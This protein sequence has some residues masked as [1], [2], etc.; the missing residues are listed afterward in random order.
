[1]LLGDTGVGKTLSTLHFLRE[2]LQCGEWCGYV[3]CDEVPAMT[4]HTLAHF[5]I[6]TAAHERSGRLRFLDAYGREGTRE[7]LAVSDPTDPEEFL[8][9][10]DRLLDSLQRCGS[11]VRLTVDSMSTILA[12]SD[13][14]TA[15][16][17]VL[18]HLRNLRARGVVSLDT[19]TS[20]VLEDRL[21]SSITQ[22]YDVVI[23]MRFADIHGTPIRLGSIDKYRFGSVTREDRIFSVQPGV[24]IVSHGTAV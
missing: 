13:Y 21:M 11:A 7:E 1:M 14:Q 8:S 23:S 6:P 24:G 16:D 22:H 10:E 17:L 2:G 18:S 20:G 15:I 3:D 19:Y 5:G 9:V 12:T 4:R